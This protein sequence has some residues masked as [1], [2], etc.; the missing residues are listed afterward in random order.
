MIEQSPDL[1]PLLNRI[2]K[3]YNGNNVFDNISVVF[4]FKRD[5]NDTNVNSRWAR[6]GVDDIQN[7][8]ILFVNYEISP[9]QTPTP[10]QSLTQSLT[11]SSTITSSFTSSVSSTSSLLPESSITP[12]E[13]PSL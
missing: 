13:S 12:T 4:I 10:T 1:S 8:P 11:S 3:S 7:A 9:S 6:S 2:L 5:F